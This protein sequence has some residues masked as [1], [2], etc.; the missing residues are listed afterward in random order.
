VTGALKQSDTA[1]TSATGY[2]FSIE[3]TVPLFSHGQA[4]VALAAASRSRAEAE[5]ES[6]RVR[7]ETEVRAAHTVLAIQQDRLARY[8][9]SAT[10]IAEP[11]AQAGPRRLRGGR[12][13]RPSPAAF[14]AR[15]N[16]FR[17]SFDSRH[18]L[19][20]FVRTARCVWVVETS[21]RK[22]AKRTDD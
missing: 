22:P 12:A 5:R 6:W 14:A 20:G 9:E 16:T 21:R 17:S 10:Q 8:R 19:P 2:Q 13:D 11:L 3:V 15:Y 4:A 1:L 18:G 7:I